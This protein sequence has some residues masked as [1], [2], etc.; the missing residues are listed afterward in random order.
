VFGH[1]DHLHPPLFSLV[2][3]HVAH[4]PAG[5]LV[6]ALVTDVPDIFVLPAGSHVANGERL[7]PTLVEGGDKV[8]GLL[9]QRITQLMQHGAQLF[10]LG[11]HEPF[12][13]A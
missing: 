11:A 7:H 3:E 4:L 1:Q 12:P 6:D 2:G 9:V 10:A 5:H 8:G 13:A